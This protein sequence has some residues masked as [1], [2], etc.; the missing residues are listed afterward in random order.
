MPL[1]TTMQCCCLKSSSF[2]IAP[3]LLLAQGCD[4]SQC[5][6]TTIYPSRPDEG[7][8]YA[9]AAILQAVFCARLAWHAGPGR[10]HHSWLNAGSTEVGRVASPCRGG[11]LRR[12]PP[13]A[14]H[15]PGLPSDAGEGWANPTRGP[16]V[17]LQL[18]RSVAAREINLS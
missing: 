16:G 8:R 9:R 2:V 15:L 1:Y 12:L 3:V 18:F 6:I 17:Q 11:P 7:Q 13:E 4:F 14:K 5:S 10:P